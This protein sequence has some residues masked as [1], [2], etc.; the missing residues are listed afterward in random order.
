MR[1]LIVF[2]RLKGRI[3]E[4]EFIASSDRENLEDRLEH[5]GELET[6]DERE[7]SALLLKHHASSVHHQMYHGVDVVG[8]SVMT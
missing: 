3:V 8:I 6:P 4:M 7:I 2:A 5:L 1:T